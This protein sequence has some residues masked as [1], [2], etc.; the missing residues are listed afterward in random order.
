MK[1]ANSLVQ[2]IE[3]NLCTGFRVMAEFIL[4]VGW[5]AELRDKMCLSAW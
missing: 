3:S 2:S 1:M 4:V 5:G